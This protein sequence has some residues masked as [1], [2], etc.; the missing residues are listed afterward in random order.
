MATQLKL[1]QLIQSGLDKSC[2]SKILQQVN[3]LL[4]SLSPSECW[5]RLADEVL[6]PLHPFALHKLLHESVFSDSDG[7]KYGP[8]P[9][10]FPSDEQVQR[11][12][13]TGLMR[14]LRI[15]SYGDFHAWS[16][17]NRA[18]FFDLM[19]ER[20]D[21]RFCKPFEAV[22]ELSH[23]AESPQWLAEAALNIAD[24]CFSASGNAPRNRLKV[25]KYVAFNIDL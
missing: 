5:Q 21:I 23:G 19:V 25:G 11:A 15:E 6:T 2:A 18:G 4:S 16:V 3:P 20:L 22:V 13:I 12:N 10:W 24:S 9:A 14:E 8:S 7:S 17:E 1:E